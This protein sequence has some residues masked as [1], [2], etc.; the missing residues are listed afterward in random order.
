MYWNIMCC[1]THL[2][3]VY[4]CKYKLR[5]RADKMDQWGNTPAAK[6]DDLGSIPV[7]SPDRRKEHELL[8]VIPWPSRMH[9]SMH[10]LIIQSSINQGK[11]I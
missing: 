5:S 4:A 7:I 8:Q 3:D 6:H 1:S 10:P 9:C 11:C 2:D